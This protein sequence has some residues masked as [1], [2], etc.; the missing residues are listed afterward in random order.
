MP[1]K[2][3]LPAANERRPHSG[4]AGIVN[5]KMNHLPSA[6]ERCSPP[7][8]R[9]RRR[10]SSSGCSIDGPRTPAI[11]TSIINILRHPTP[12]HIS[13]NASFNTSPDRNDRTHREAISSNTHPLRHKLTQQST[14]LEKK[15]N[16]MNN[17]VKT[18]NQIKYNKHRLNIKY[19]SAFNMRCNLLFH[20]ILLD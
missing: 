19:V 7:Y 16:K 3:K 9:Y 8:C 18:I 12:F 17:L 4:I 6:N 11:W 10:G 1:K 2:V 14:R 20:Y 15:H 5:A 13:A